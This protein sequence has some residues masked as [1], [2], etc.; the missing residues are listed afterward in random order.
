M[1]LVAPIV[2]PLSTAILTLLVRGRGPGRVISLLG[3]V[4]LLISGIALLSE[5]S[6]NG[7]MAG[8]MGAWAAPFG[9]RRA[10]SSCPPVERRV[11]SIGSSMS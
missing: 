5:V 2:V 4:G 3:A 7:P 11:R 8:Q 6:E 9:R 1:L 10:A